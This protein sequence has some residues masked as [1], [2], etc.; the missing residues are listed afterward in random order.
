MGGHYMLGFIREMRDAG[1]SNKQIIE[2]CACC[3]LFVVAVVVLMF[4]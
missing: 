2:E 3:V 4:I 1:L